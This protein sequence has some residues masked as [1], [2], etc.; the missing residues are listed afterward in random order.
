MQSITAAKDD[1][2][3]IEENNPTERRGGFR[4][5]SSFMH[6]QKKTRNFTCL[7]C[8]VEFAS[9]H[10][11]AKFCSIPKRLTDKARKSRCF[12]PPSKA[13]SALL[14]KARKGK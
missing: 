1:S 13:A 14:L 12:R 10:V 11:G 4:K 6:R 8:R 9:T 2:L 5:N 7:W 3:E